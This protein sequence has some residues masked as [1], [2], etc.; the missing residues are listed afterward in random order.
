MRGPNAGTAVWITWESQPR[1]RS[2]AREVGVPLYEF[3]FS[4]SRARR[5][6]RAVGA[7]LSLLLRQRPGVVFA[8]NPSLML[9]YLMLACRPLF[10]FR[11]ASDAHYGG[12]VAVHGSTLLQWLL[13]FANARAD[14]VI[15]TNEVHAERVRR[16]GGAPFV[17]PDPLPQLPESPSKPNG[18][19]GAEK[20]VLFICSFEVDEPYTQVFDAA[21]VLAGH[22]FTVFASGPYSR[23]GLAPDAVPHVT[24]LGYVDRPTY[25][26]YLQHADIILDLTTWQDC[27]VCGAYEAMAAGK[28][29]VLSRTAALTSLF[30]HGT[31][32][33]SHGPADIADAVLSAYERREALKT[34]IAEWVVGHEAAIRKRGAALRAAVELPA[35]G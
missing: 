18:M 34:Q 2:M 5:Q 8:S 3:S 10:G 24:L 6:L 29:C 15:V 35:L 30:T 4:G 1:N 25:D 22:G 31:V 20:S 28:P 16:V 19:R 7:T 26:A 12:V 32:F 27:L 23:A 33:S 11:F 9:T 14:L 21:R 13:D 17:C